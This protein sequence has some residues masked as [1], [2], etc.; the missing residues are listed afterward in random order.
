MRRLALTASVFASL[1]A[2]GNAAAAT[3]YVSANG[4]DANPGT[5]TTA[6]WRTVGKVNAAPLAPGDRVLFQGGQTF[7]DSTLMPSA[8]GS[9][10]AP[11]TFASF[12]TGQAT[13][14]NSN[15]AVWFSGKHYLTF[16]NLGLTSGG[17]SNGI[18]AG[19]GGGASDHIVLS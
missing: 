19:S 3:F 9:A 11:I 7:S 4:S 5:S 17:S 6:P 14:S 16:D 8:S 2:A 10:G 1:L 12:G 13:I 15:G 18:F